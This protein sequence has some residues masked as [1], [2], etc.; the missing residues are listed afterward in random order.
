MKQAAGKLVA[1]FLLVSCLA[2]TSNLKMEA[3]GS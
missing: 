3:S 2:D 1:F